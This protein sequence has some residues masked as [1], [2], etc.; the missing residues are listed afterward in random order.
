MRPRRHLVIMA[1]APRLGRVKRRL[2]R[3]IGAGAA[4]VFYRAALRRLLRGVGRDPRWR[5]WL[6]VTPDRAARGAA[7][8]AQRLPRRPQ[9]RGDLG[10]RMRRPLAELPPGPVVI[11][12]S[13]IPAIAPRHL[14]AA[15]RAL[16]R[17]D[18]VFGPARDGGYWLVGARRRPHLPRLFARVRWSGPHALADTLA[19]LGGRYRIATL[20]A[21]EDVDDGESYRRWRGRVS[22]PASDAPGA[23]A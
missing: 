17:D 19:G 8:W 10:A 6:Y 5:S 12:G 21:L 15:F 16:G 3:E 9:G 4:L 1:K 18:L 22:P 11:V 13:D 23:A 14:V 2:A 20:E 7:P